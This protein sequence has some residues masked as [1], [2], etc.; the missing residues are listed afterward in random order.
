M[1]SQLLQLLLH[2]HQLS[3][4]KT[5]NLPQKHQQLQN[6]HQ[7]NILVKMLPLET[8]LLMLSLWKMS[9]L[10]PKPLELNQNTFLLQHSLL[11]IL[12]LSH[13]QKLDSPKTYLKVMTKKM[14]QLQEP[15]TLLISLNHQLFTEI[16]QLLLETTPLTLSPLLIIESESKPSEPTQST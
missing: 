15:Q 1:R 2:H 13:G 11:I 16:S 4:L 6:Y 12:T 3:V 8:P 14:H 10:V 5:Q 9:K 7:L